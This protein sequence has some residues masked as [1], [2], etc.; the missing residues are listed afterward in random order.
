MVEGEGD[1]HLGMGEEEVAVVE[2]DR[3]GEVVVGEEGVR[4]RQERGEE[5]EEVDHVLL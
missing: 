5:A 2:G 3:Q 4:H 1:H